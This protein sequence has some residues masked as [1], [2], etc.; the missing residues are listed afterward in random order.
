MMRSTDRIITSHAGTLPR[1]PEL[2]AIMGPLFGTQ[3]IDEA[4]FKR[5]VP[6]LVRDVV[7]R[8][9]DIGIDIVNDGEYG[10][11]GGFSFYVQSR[12]GGLEEA[13]PDEAPEPHNITARDQ[14]EFPGFFAANMGGFA[15]MT[16]AQTPGGRPVRINAPIFARQPLTYVGQEQVQFDIANIKAAMEGIQGHQPYLPAVAPGTIEHWLWNRYYKDDREFLFA[17]ADVMHEEYKAIT[18]AGIVLQIDDPD[19][20]DG[21]QMFPEMSVEDYRRY[22]Q[23]RVEAL[24]HALRDCPRELVRLHV[25]W[26][27][28]HGPHKNDIDLRHIIDIIFNVKA[29]CYSIEASNARHEHEWEVFETVKLPDGATLMPGVIGHATD[30]VEHPELVAQRLVRY[31]NLVGRENVIAGTDCGLGGRVGHA[32]IAWAKLE[33]MVEGARIATKKLWG[34]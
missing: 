14:K 10:K 18:D 32:E 19:L 24:N 16:G 25:C 30:L 27:S 23:L 28:G 11:R 29:E 9:V 15:R 26:G 8:Q 3:Q 5:V 31:A 1:P 21:W 2:E 20:P 6:G 17:I 22:A 12:I 34:R 33:A 4:E 13:P 7:R